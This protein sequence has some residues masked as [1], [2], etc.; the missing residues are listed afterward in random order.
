MVTVGGAGRTLSSRFLINKAF[1]GIELT[2]DFNFNKFTKK[3]EETK[4][5]KDKTEDCEGMNYVLMFLVNFMEPDE[6]DWNKFSYYD[7]I[8]AERAIHDAV[9]TYTEDDELVLDP[10]S[11]LCQ[12]ISL[13]KIIKKS[14]EIPYQILQSPFPFI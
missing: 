12:I 14:T 3:L 2:F 9:V 13:G 11:P 10:A 7:C 8:L 1:G 6:V 5:E 4:V